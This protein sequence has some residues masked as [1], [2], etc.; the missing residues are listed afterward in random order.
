MDIDIKDTIILSDDNEYV[1][2][3]KTSYKDD[4]YYFLIDEN[5]YENIKFCK[6]NIINS[7]LLEVDDGA[8]IKELLP[9]F[10]KSSTNSITKEDLELIRKIAE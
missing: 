10:L 4:V 5:N 8:L 7:S 6:E 9:L 1:V 2:T 3:S